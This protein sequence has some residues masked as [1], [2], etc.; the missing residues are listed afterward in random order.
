[1]PLSANYFD[2][3]NGISQSQYEYDLGQGQALLR[4]FQRWGDQVTTVFVDG[5]GLTAGQ[6]TTLRTYYATLRTE[7]QTWFSSLPTP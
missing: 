3:P 1:M 6:K 4:K 2:K 7:L 5:S